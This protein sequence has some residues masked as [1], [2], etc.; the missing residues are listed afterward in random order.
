[1][2]E[3]RE[4]AVPV[5]ASSQCRAMTTDTYERC[6]RSDLRPTVPHEHETAVQY[7]ARKAAENDPQPVHDPVEAPPPGAVPDVV[8]ASPDLVPDAP[9]PPESHVPDARRT[10]KVTRRPFDH[11]AA[12]ARAGSEGIGY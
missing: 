6:C 8:P 11:E 12:R 1:M 5:G 9:T 7:L 4:K 2:T 10:T 3:W